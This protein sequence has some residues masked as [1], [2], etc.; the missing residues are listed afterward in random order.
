MKKL[1]KVLGVVA[2]GACVALSA[3]ATTIL[4]QSS[5]YQ[6]GS[7]G[8]FS[9]TPTGVLDL[10]SYDT[11]TLNVGNKSGSFQSFCIEYQEHISYNGTYNLEL[12]NPAAVEGGVPGGQDTL[13]QG[14]GW[15]YSQF[16][17]GSLTGY[18]IGN[19]RNNAGLLQNA[20]WTLEEESG[21]S[22]T[23]GANLFLDAVAGAFMTGTDSYYDGF[24][25]AQADGADDYGVFALNLKTFGGGLAQDQLYY[26]EKKTV[27][28]GGMT[29]ALLGVA[30][31]GLA[32]LRRR[33]S[34]A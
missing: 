25:K 6:N 17:D 29:V 1:N 15:L 23:Q 3:S 5:P 4:F 28:D 34:K 18:F 27:P 10:S 12:V 8:E 31:A 33:S 22:Y 20:F 16:A 19:R 2:V 7:G 24:A 13:S 30:M 14:T 9:L 32:A 11:K 26:K 21:F